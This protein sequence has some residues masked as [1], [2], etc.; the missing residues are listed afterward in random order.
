MNDAGVSGNDFLDRLVDR[1]LGRSNAVAPRLPHVFEPLTVYVPSDAAVSDRA[2]PERYPSRVD[3][4]GNHAE[5]LRPEA[6]YPVE[7]VAA[8]DPAPTTAL[9][10]ILSLEPKDGETPDPVASERRGASHEPAQ[11]AEDVRSMQA[12][13]AK[14]DSQKRQ[15]AVTLRKTEK[16]ERSSRSLSESPA[17][18]ST[19]ENEVS[20][21][22][23]T[24]SQL[25]RRSVA[26]N[27]EPSPPR[28]ERW[29]DK[30]PA[31]GI[32]VAKSMPTLGPL[33][34]AVPRM[35]RDETAEAVGPESVINVTI[36]RVE[37]RA[38]RGSTALPRGQGETNRRVP[39]SLGDYLK[40]RGEGK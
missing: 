13:I 11:Q 7:P 30:M 36:G 33:R 18:Y 15:P 12:Q 3:V 5:K 19:E 38:V 14:S 27:P 25:Q 9:S 8:L 34:P 6:G 31:T 20:Q 23:S 39:L 29:P 17:L 10:P 26:A 16:E 4:E 21:P 35:G 28:D 2:E 1:T 32:L 37:V 22:S 40:R 24:E